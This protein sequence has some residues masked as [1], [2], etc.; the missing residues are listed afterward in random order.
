MYRI[1]SEDDH[2][3]DDHHDDGHADE[4]LRNIKIVVLFAMLIAGAFV[5]L[6]FISFFKEGQPE[7]K[8]KCCKGKMFPYCNCFAAGMLLT[9]AFCHILPE[10]DV[11]FAEFREAKELLEVAAP[12]EDHHDEDEDH[13]EDE[14][15]SG[16]DDE[17]DEHGHGEE[18]GDEHGFPI[19]HCLF[20]V[21]FVFM[22]LLDRVLF[23]TAEIEIGEKTITKD[24]IE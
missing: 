1:L 22:L 24:Q 15:E 16:H 4:K 3:E 8:K 14:A 5:F 12:R 2:H 11:M 17:H 10:A 18:H 9:L 13:H 21:G 23:G 20:L 6:P 7:Q 19:A